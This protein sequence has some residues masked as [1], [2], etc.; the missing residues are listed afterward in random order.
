MAMQKSEPLDRQDNDRLQV[1]VVSVSQKYAGLSDLRPAVCIIIADP[2]RAA[3]FLKLRL[4][5]VYGLTE[6]EAQLAELLANGEKLRAARN[7]LKL[8]ALLLNTLA[9]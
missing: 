9:V 5:D 8:V 2:D 3:P 4:K 1:L 6:A 7:H